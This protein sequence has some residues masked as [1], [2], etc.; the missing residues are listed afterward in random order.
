VEFGFV[1]EVVVH[2]EVA[3]II[4]VGHHGSI[5]SEAGDHAVVEAFRVEGYLFSDFAYLVLGLWIV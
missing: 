5:A 1:E 4:F 3:E 2:L